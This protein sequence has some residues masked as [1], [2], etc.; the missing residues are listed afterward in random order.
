MKFKEQQSKSNMRKKLKTTNNI[1]DIEYIKTDI[2]HYFLINVI[3]VAFLH[4]F[5]LQFK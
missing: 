5:I 3:P 1:S 4:S 2:G